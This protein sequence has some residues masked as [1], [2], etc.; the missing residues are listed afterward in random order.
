P[1]R[2]RAAHSAAGRSWAAPPLT[3]RELE[4]WAALAEGRSNREIAEAHF[5]SEATVKTHV[6]TL[7]S[8]LGVRTRVQAVIAA[9]D[10]GIVSPDVDS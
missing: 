5:V 3:S 10:A 4:T 7:L 6:S 9:Y 8:K 2:L 1:S